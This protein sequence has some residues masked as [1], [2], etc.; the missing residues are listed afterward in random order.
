MREPLY[1]TAIEAREQLFIEP[2]RT[3]LASLSQKVINVGKELNL[4][5]GMVEHTG[6]VLTLN[7]TDRFEEG[8]QGALP[9]NYRTPRAI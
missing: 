1:W 2:I 3:R 6:F 9:A 4:S 7:K 8:V 5:D